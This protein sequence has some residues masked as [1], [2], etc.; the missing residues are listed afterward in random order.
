[1][2]ATGDTNGSWGDADESTTVRSQSKDAS[3]TTVTATVVSISRSNMG[4][5]FGVLQAF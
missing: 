3:V 4:V 2:S 5:E 1:M